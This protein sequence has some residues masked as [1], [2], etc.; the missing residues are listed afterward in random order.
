MSK[1]NEAKKSEA[2]VGDMV[3]MNQ[4][5]V[6]ASKGDVGKVLRIFGDGDIYKIK[7]QGKH[8][9][10]T[11][12]ERFDLV[13][14]APGQPVITKP[15]EKKPGKKGIRITVREVKPDVF[16]IVDFTALDYRFLPLEYINGYPC[17]SVTDSQIGIVK[18]KG[19]AEW[20]S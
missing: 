15:P 16:G 4:H 17:V 12:S 1:K 20:L 10:I 8:P 19:C 7:I 9:F 3:V 11:K 14:L 5:Y 6:P 18:A 2:K 13:G